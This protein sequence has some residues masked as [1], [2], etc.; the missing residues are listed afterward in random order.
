MFV[1]VQLERW[2]EA[3]LKEKRGFHI[4]PMGEDG[5]CMFRA[6]GRC[7][8]IRN[9]LEKKNKTERS[10]TFFFHNPNL[11]CDAIKNK[12]EFKKIIITRQS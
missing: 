8:I 1:S 10:N 9:V 3:T 12:P 7:R 11:V 5:A 6:V 4:K 2:F